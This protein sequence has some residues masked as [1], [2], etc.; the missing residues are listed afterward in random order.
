MDKNLVIVVTASALL[1]LTF[2]LGATGIGVSTSLSWVESIDKKRVNSSFLCEEGPLRV[3]LGD[4]TVTNTLPL[5]KRVESPAD[6]VCVGDERYQYNPVE[7]NNESIELLDAPNGISSYTAT[8]LLHCQR[9]LRPT[10]ISEG[11]IPNQLTFIKGHDCSNPEHVVQ[12]I[13]V[14]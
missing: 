4:V 14:E 1:A 13:T 10:N 7:Y 5:T 9:P 11:D 3:K 12:R 2:V 6:T 8:T